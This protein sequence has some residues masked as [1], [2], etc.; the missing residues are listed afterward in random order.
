MSKKTLEVIIVGEPY[1]LVTDESEE[2]I[3]HAAQ[4]TDSTIRNIE[5]AG[6]NDQKRVVV[7]AA[8]Q[9][10]SQFLKM[11]REQKELLSDRDYLDKWMECQNKLLS[12][13]F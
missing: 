4:I 7:L 1:T 2:H 10:A 5:R 8:L 11:E 9:I 3:L 6:I 12:D 13:F